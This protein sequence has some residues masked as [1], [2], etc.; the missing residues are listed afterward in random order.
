[1]SR[2]SLCKNPRCYRPDFQYR[3]HVFCVLI[4]LYLKM[5]WFVRRYRARHIR[6]HNQLLHTQSMWH[7][8]IGD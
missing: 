6:A 2:I 8:R 1:M 7:Y 5:C 4:W 3:T